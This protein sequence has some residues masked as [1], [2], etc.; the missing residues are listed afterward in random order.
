MPRT[1]SLH[2]L[3]FSLFLSASAYAQGTITC[4]PG[5]SGV[6][7]CPCTNAPSGPG[8]GCNNSA[9]TGGAALSATGTASLSGDSVQFD[10]NFIGSTGPACNTPT[11]NLL[12]VLYQG[13]LPI[14]NG[15]VWGDGVLCCLGNVLPLSIGTSNAGNYH[16]PLPGTSMVSM[17]SAAMGDVLSSGATRCYFVAY[18][19]SCPT[20]CT[21]SFRQKTNS[22]TITWTP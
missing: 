3:A 8:R 13:S 22:Y 5:V 20:F 21:P 15:I 9:S 18:R 10:A 7:P 6:V 16:Y 11:G 19:D 17:Q 2:L 4:E 12:S 1:R 14:A